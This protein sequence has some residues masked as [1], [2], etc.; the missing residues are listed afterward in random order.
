MLTIKI[1]LK[2]KLIKQLNKKNY[3]SHSFCLIATSKNDT[4]HYY[5]N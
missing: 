2:K 5:F 3:I 4:T 1:H